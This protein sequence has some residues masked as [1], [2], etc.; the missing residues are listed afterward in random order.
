MVVAE[1]KRVRPGVGMQLITN[2]VE[3]GRE[4]KNMCCNNTNGVSSQ[5]QSCSHNHV[6]DAV[7][8]ENIHS[9]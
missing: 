3:P 9:Y 4:V 2:M 5:Y 1:W 8:I 6:T 7:L